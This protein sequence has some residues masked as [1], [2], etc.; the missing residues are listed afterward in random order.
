MTNK[1]PNT[2]QNRR[3][4]YT[5][6]EDLET[7]HYV[8]NPPESGKDAKSVPEMFTPVPDI[9]MALTT[10]SEKNSMPIIDSGS[11]INIIGRPWIQ[12]KFAKQNPVYFE[13][14]PITTSFGNL[15]TMKSHE[16]IFL[17]LRDRTHKTNFTAQCY[18]VEEDYP[19]S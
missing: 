18:V 4:L 15:G 8:S 5:V 6:R 10:K 9:C 17:R 12:R 7:N 2:T 3:Y 1:T 13:Q 14:D 11:S 16:T 19:R